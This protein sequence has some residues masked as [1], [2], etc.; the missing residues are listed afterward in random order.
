MT[1]LAW[2]DLA[3]LALTAGIALPASALDWN[4]EALALYGGTYAA[5]CAN[6]AALHLRVESDKLALEK[7]S[8]TVIARQPDPSASFFG[9]Q[10]PREFQI[11]IMGSVAAAGDLTVIVYRD[12]RGRYAGL[13]ADP[14]LMASLDLKPN[15]TT[16]YR[17]CDAERRQR[18]GAADL[19][20]QS[21]QGKAAEDAA[22]ASPLAD[23]AFKAAYLTAIGSRA[24]TEWL[25]NLDGPG[26]P[27]KSVVIDGVPYLQLAFCKAHD[28]SD[29]NTVLLYA[30]AD[31]K[32]Y[33]LVFEGGQ[34]STLIGN[35]PAPLAEE[36]RRIWRSEWR[37]RR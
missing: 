27:Q 4:A 16:T 17:D 2:P 31:N 28:C 3:A 18:D 29:N 7:G 8:R 21:A 26:S 35:P 25:A 22:L 5:D 30:R 14:A 20:A 24:R 6:P 15:D 19:A 37:Q 33:G 13:Q 36:L 23:P 10:P 34:R 12:A 11:A 9:P 1:R 32:V